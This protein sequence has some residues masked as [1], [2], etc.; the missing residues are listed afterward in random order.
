MEKTNN[1]K[2]SE[3]AKKQT[4][5][6]KQTNKNKKTKKQNKEGSKERSW[7]NVHYDVFNFLQHKDI[8]FQEQRNS[9]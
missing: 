3:K 5:K 9:W 7:Q 1:Q 6:N 4:R 2:T 8:Y